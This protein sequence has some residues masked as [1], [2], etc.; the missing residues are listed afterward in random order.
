MGPCFGKVA[1]SWFTSLLCVVSGAGWWTIQGMS[2]QANGHLIL[3]LH[4]VV[5]LYVLGRTVTQMTV[6]EF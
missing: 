3:G 4:A 5:I 1:Q 6:V 2:N